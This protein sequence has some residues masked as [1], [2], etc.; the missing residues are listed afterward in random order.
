MEL[1]RGRFAWIVKIGEK[2]QFV[3]PKEAR[4][5]FELHPGNEILVL[6]DTE[7]GLAIL[8]KSKQADIIANIFIPDEY[9][10][11]KK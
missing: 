2:G 9:W 8:P 5:I 7:R 4:D 1:P 6:G 11:D 3:I 10:E